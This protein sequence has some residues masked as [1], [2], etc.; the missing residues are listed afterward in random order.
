V[1]ILV[2]LIIW[3][4]NTTDKVTQWL[5][6]NEEVFF[7]LLL[8]PI[9][10]ESGFSLQTRDFFNNFG[11]RVVASLP[12]GVTIRPARVA[13]TPGRCQIAYVD[14]TGCHQLVF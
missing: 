14:H 7:F 9:I 10:F 6:F 11:G 8:P 12:G 1:G 2:G 13:L 3:S 5:D 4:A